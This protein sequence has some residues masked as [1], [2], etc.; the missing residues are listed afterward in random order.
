MIV[1]GYYNINNGVFLGPMTATNEATGVASTPRYIEGVCFGDFNTETEEFVPLT[2][3]MHI[4]KGMIYTQDEQITADGKLINVRTGIEEEVGAD[5]VSKKYVPIASKR[6]PN[7]ET[8]DESG[9]IYPTRPVAVPTVKP[10][11]EDET[12][13]PVV[14]KPRFLNK[15]ELAFEG[16]DFENLF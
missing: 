5:F 6:T 15:Q 16:I 10:K 11:V 9:K 13:E 1:K 8:R 4:P 3:P 12:I 14:E 2:N 7:V